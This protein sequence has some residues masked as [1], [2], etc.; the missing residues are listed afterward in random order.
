MG[1]AGIVGAGLQY[2]DPKSGSSITRNGQPIRL[3]GR[4]QLDNIIVGA[5]TGPSRII[6]IARE[7]ADEWNDC[8]K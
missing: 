7:I 4:P 1:G 8:D 6:I 2:I 5:A 3:T